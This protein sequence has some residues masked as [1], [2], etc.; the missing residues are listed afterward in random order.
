MAG[1]SILFPDS[2]DAQPNVNLEQGTPDSSSV[3]LRLSGSTEPPAAPS[4]TGWW[5]PVVGSP[6][7]PQLVRLAQSSL[8]ADADVT[9]W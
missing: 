8:G 9:R 6:A 4:R 7:Y 2:G 5:L 3:P 1:R